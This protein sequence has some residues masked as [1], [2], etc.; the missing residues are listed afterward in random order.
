MSPVW[1]DDFGTR[2]KNSRSLW[3]GPYIYLFMGATFLAMSA[4][5][6]KKFVE[7]RGRIVVED[8]FY[9]HFNR[10]RNIFVNFEFQIKKFF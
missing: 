4:S 6:L 5:P 7:L 9:T 1:E 10:P 3:L 2:P 8:C